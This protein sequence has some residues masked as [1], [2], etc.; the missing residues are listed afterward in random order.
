M[1]PLIFCVACAAASDGGDGRL[2]LTDTVGVDRRV[3]FPG[4]KLIRSRQDRLEHPGQQG[5]HQQRHFLD[6]KQDQVHG[7]LFEAKCCCTRASTH[8]AKTL[9]RSRADVCWGKRPC[10]TVD[11]LVVGRIRNGAGACA[12]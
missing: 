2:R 9:P 12:L 1:F 11:G 7:R 4:F 3:D 6:Q 5:H 10:C 8:V